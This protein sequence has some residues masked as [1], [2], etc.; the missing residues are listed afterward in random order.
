MLGIGSLSNLLILSSNTPCEHPNEVYFSKKIDE[1][2]K[3]DW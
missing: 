1:A 3:G 2:E